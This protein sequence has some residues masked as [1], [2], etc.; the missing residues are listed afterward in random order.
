MDDLSLAHP[1]VDH[2]VELIER[3]RITHVRD[4]DHARALLLR[5]APW[6][7][8][9]ADWVVDADVD[10]GVD[11]DLA[12]GTDVITVGGEFDVDDRAGSASRPPTTRARHLGTGGEPVARSR[13]PSSRCAATRAS[14][15]TGTRATTQ[16]GPGPQCTTLTFADTVV[17]RRRSRTRGMS[18]ASAIH[19]A[20]RT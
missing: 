10:V 15:E 3:D 16:R 5:H 7:E 2:D 4:E 20:C 1:H 13:S 19:R 6:Y 8:R 12:P 14:R 11:V 9:W 18:R 17:I